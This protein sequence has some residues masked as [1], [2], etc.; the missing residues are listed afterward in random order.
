MG[1]KVDVANSHVI[2]HGEADECLVMDQEF[3]LRTVKRLSPNHDD[4]LAK[5]TKE[6]N[7]IVAKLPK[8]NSEGREL[9]LII[10]AS[11][12]VLAWCEHEVQEG[13]NPPKLTERQERVEKILGLIE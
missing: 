6:I 7:A 8:K 3:L 2:C 9:S 4:I 12:P 1:K 10:T 13:L 11:G 5:A